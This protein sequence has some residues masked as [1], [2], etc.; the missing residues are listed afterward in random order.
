MY[1][2]LPL[3]VIALESVISSQALSVTGMY[4]M[5]QLQQFITVSPVSTP[6]HSSLLLG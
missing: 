3:T 4:Q 6:S 2:L 1:R 5:E